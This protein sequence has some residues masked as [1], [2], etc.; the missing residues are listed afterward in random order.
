MAE[1]RRKPDESVFLESWIS[2]SNKVF[3]VFR[4]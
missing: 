4:P 1:L 2:N 3:A